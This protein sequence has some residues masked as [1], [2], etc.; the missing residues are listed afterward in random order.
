[1]KIYLAGSDVFA[2]DAAERGERMKQLCRMYDME[3]LYPL[4]QVCRT[5]EEIFEA[6]TALIRACDAVAANINPFRGNEP[7]SGTAF[8]IG[9]A[10]AMGKRIFCYADDMRSLREKLGAEDT[11]G[12]MV[13]DFDLPFNLMIAV[14]ARLVR[15]DFEDCIRAIRR[16]S[17]KVEL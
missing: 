14:P 9:Y 4:D 5:A 6:N 16:E 1:M 8:E 11:D 7:D 17:D 2:Y 3:G 12:Y 13:E 10:Y 15:G